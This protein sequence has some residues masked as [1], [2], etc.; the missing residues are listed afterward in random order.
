MKTKIS[1][2]IV[3]MFVIGAVTLAL[4]A[5]LSFGGINFFSKPQRFVVYFDESIHGL[6]LGSPVKLRGVRVGRVVDLNVQFDT[7]S[8]NSVV[9]VICE[10]SRSTVKDEIGAMIDV[11]SRK[12]LEKLITQGLRAQL[13]VSGLA[14]G[15]L[16][17]ELDFVDPTVANP[18][19]TAIADPKFVVVPSVRSAIS[20]FQASLTEILTNL[21]GVDFGGLSKEMN[22]LL[23]DVRKQVVGLELAKLSAEWTQ[24][25]A[26]VNELAR[27]GE[28]QKTFAHLNE[29]IDQLSKMVAGVDAQ[30]Q[31]AGVKLNEALVEAKVVLKSFNE[32]ADS[33][34][35]FIT[36]QGGL[37]EETVR[38]MNQL[39]EAAASVQRLAEFLERNPNALLTGKKQPK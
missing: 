9:E 4:I 11:S 33:A 25:G 17:V 13:G 15:L 5:L 34:R 1:P 39:A 3:G 19:V 8:K 24:A 20:E 29:A 10:F 7:R 37:G 12:E 14:T 36:A 31:P 18:T 21:K 2:T 27:S 26:A 28:L 30:I 38:T 35:R 16:F 22:G 32:A 23:V 6:D